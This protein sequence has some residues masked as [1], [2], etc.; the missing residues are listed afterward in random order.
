[1]CGDGEGANRK[2]IPLTVTLFLDPTASHIVDKVMR[3]FIF[4][5]VSTTTANSSPQKKKNARICQFVRLWTYGRTSNDDNKKMCLLIRRYCAAEEHT[6]ILRCLVT[7]T[8]IHNILDGYS[9]CTACTTET[10]IK[11]IESFNFA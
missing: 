5:P 6:L 11:F 10:Q 8:H 2:R 7:H 3:N 4:N 1:M 9:V